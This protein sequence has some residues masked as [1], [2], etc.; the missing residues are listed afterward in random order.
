MKRAFLIAG[1]TVG[2]LG[3]VL[4]ITPPQLNTVTSAGTLSGSLG[5]GT[6]AAQATTVAA[7]QAAAAPAATTATKSAASKASH[8]STQKATTSASASAS[9][10][11]SAAS[12]QSASPTPTPAKTTAAPTATG[13]YSGTITGATFAA[14]NYGNLA[15]TV[16]FKD[17]KIA[18]VSASQSPTSWSEQSLSALIPYVNGGKITIEQIKQYAAEQLPCAISN[19][20]RS[21]ASFSATAFWS[22]VKSAI[23][24]AGL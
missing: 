7:T 11:Q 20:C 8:K 19:S 15:A 14:R 12:T 17:G 10:S 16:T 6:G 23:S 21:Q 13:G 3:A 1:G 4:A 9:A 22:S 5:G 18:S 24:K 2:G